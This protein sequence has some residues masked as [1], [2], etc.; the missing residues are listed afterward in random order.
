MS[1][2]SGRK[3]LP[4]D[5]STPRARTTLGTD[6]L[7]V[8]VRTPK[9]VESFLQ[10]QWMRLHPC[11]AIVALSEDD[12]TS[13]E[14]QVSKMMPQYQEA[15]RRT[16]SSATSAVA[17][18]TAT[19]RTNQDMAVNASPFF[20]ASGLHVDLCDLF[21]PP[22]LSNSLLESRQVNENPKQNAAKKKARV[23]NDTNMLRGNL[24]SAISDQIKNMFQSVLD[25][26]MSELAGDSPNT[27]HL[28]T[29][30]E[31][32]QSM[33]PNSLLDHLSSQNVARTLES[34]K[35]INYYESLVIFLAL[36]AEHSSSETLGRHILNVLTPSLLSQCND[37]SPTVSFALKRLSRSLVYQCSL[38]K[39]TKAELR[40]LIPSNPTSQ[41]LQE[42]ACCTAESYFLANQKENNI[43]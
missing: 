23:E 4:I 34:Y 19:L 35:E 28:S 33:S 41:A 17:E 37:L 25:V 7:H 29:L 15:V 39:L 12:D 2:T 24:E 30:L 6:A 31:P 9:N 18:Q 8:P 13:P 11:T 22:L 32:I 42:L 43:I 21:D 27:T 5:D 10:F 26:A 1:E 36:F 16:N 14:V 38:S 3:D 20:Q 40:S